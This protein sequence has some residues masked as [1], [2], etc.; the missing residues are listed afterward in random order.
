[1]KSQGKRKIVNNRY[2]KTHKDTQRHTKRERKRER[3]RGRD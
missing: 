2:A 3:K 1:M